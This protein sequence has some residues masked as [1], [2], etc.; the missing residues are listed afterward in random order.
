MGVMWQS[1]SPADT[2]SWP[3]YSGNRDARAALTEI[4]KPLVRP[5]RLE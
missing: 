5:V 4:G 3:T 1:A 2:R